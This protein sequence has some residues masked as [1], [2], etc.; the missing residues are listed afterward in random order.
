MSKN[1]KSLT[2]KLPAETHHKLKMIAASNNKSMTDVIIDFVDN[3]NIKIPSFMVGG[4][5]TAGSSKANKSVELVLKVNKPVQLTADKEEIKKSVL[6]WRAEKVPYQE[7]ADRFNEQGVPTKSGR[8]SWKKGSIQRDYKKW[9]K[10]DNSDGE[11]G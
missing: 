9:T 8:G 4:K 5:K 7:I 2:L 1:E 6:A 3:T 11:N 10:A